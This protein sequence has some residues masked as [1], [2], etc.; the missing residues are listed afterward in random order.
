ML[1]HISL[2]VSD[3]QRASAFYDPALLPLGYVRVWSDS[4]AIGYGLPGGGDKLALKLK[5]NGLV[6]PGPGFHL[7]LSAPTREAVV[8]FHE[9]ALANGGKSNGA[10]SLRP[11]YG[12]NY[13]AAFVLDPDGYHIEAVINVPA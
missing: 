2:G 12:P 11:H 1:H 9:A 10:P 5:P 4:T 3:L 7:A 13:Y 6:I 8:Q